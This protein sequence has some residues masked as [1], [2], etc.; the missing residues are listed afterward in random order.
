MMQISSGTV[1]YH[2]YTLLAYYKPFRNR[3]MSTVW[4]I[5]GNLESANN[6]FKKKRMVFQILLNESYFQPS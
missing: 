5:L 4:F 3:N 2:V 1:Q 6:I